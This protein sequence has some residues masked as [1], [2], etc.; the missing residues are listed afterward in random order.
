MAVSVVKVVLLCSFLFIGMVLGGVLMQPKTSV[1]VWNVKESDFPSSGD[2]LSFLLNYAILAPSSQNSQPWKFN[3]SGDEIRLFAD[4]T[5]WLAV[6]DADQRELYI[7]QGTALENLLVA[8]DHF[9]YGYNVTYP[10]GNGSLVAV[11]K[12]TP[13]SGHSQ[14]PKLF[15]AI[16]DLRTNQNPY[17]A[18]EIPESSLQA[19]ENTSLNK[20]VKLVLASDANTRNE[21]RNL[22]LSAD[23]KQ[24]TDPNYKSELGHSIGEGMMGPTSIQAVLAQLRVLFLDIS[25]DQ[26]KKDSDLVNS[27]PTLGFIISDGND[28]VSQIKSGQLLE[29]IWLEATAMGISLQP[30]SQALEMPD[31]KAELAKLLSPDSGNIQQVFTLGYASS[32]EDFMPRT[33]VQDSIVPVNWSQK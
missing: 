25:A 15:K 28:R 22:T 27:T 19:L 31:T 3:A 26:T 13:G 1:D 33:S 29:R 12:L 24:Y 7:S 14:D 9:G 32:V 20:D 5:R 18:K 30:M 4:K 11:I 6:S 17:E 23:Q 8:A 21:F 16:V 2:K 10:S